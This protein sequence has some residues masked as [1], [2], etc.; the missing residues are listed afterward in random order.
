MKVLRRGGWECE[1][2]EEGWWGCEDVEEGW[3][4]YVKMQGPCPH[5][6]CY[7]VQGGGEGGGSLT[8]LAALIRWWYLLTGNGTCEVLQAT[9]GATF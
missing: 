2:V 6:C 3:V 5:V 7:L 8:P 9:S 4:G 1:D